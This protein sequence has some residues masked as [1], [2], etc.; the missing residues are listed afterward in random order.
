MRCSAHTYN[1]VASSDV[2]S[3][4]DDATFKTAFRRFLGKAQ[5]LWNTQNRSTV[6]A[7]IIFEELA[8][9]FTTPNETRWNALFDSIVSLLKTAEEKRSGLQRVMTK[10]KIALFTDADLDFAREYISVRK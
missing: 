9:R 3:A 1:L 5:A 4:M 8:L 2:N 7:D 6:S 10:L